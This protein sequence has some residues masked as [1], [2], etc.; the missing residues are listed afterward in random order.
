MGEEKKTQHSSSWSSSSSSFVWL[1]C[2]FLYIIFVICIQYPFHQRTR[3][4][5]EIKIMLFGGVFFCVLVFVFV[6]VLV[7]FYLSFLSGFR[8]DENSRICIFYDY[9]ECDDF[10][11][12][13][14]TSE[15]RHLIGFCWPQPPS[16]SQKPKTSEQKKCCE[17]QKKTAATVKSRVSFLC[18][19]ANISSRSTLSPT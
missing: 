17:R 13:M 9:C 1:W 5:N 11:M 7:D 16:S 4:I 8:C 18:F 3:T 10:K 2:N 12:F 15:K 6:F 14:C 19:F